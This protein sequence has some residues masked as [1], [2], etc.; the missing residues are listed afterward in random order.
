[1]SADGIGC[2]FGRRA[3]LRITAFCQSVLNSEFRQ[4]SAERLVLDLKLVNL[5][6]ST[7]NKGYV[8]H[9]YW[10]DEKVL[11]SIFHLLSFPI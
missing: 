10:T 1:M 7:G 3:L 2:L 4:E 11:Y 6:G 5:K 8:I 9:L